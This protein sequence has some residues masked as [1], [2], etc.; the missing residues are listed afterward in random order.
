MEPQVN[1]DQRYDSLLTVYR[2]GSFA[3]AAAEMSLTAS[4]VSKQIHSLERD[5]DR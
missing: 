4:A 5:L 2:L 3:A 1:Y